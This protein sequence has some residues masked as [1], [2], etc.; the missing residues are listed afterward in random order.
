MACRTPLHIWPTRQQQLEGATLE[1][2]P[3]LAG[4]RAASAPRHGALR[5][6]PYKSGDM[7]IKCWEIGPGTA[8][9]DAV[10]HIAK[11]ASQPGQSPGRPQSPG[12]MVRGGAVGVSGDIDAHSE[13]SHEPEGEEAEGAPARSGSGTAGIGGAAAA[14]A[15]VPPPAE[16]AQGGGGGGSELGSGASTPR[17]SRLIARRN[18]LAQRPSLEAAA[19]LMAPRSPS[20]LLHDGGATLRSYGLR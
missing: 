18:S 2:R 1:R 8:V 4:G 10:A 14:G 15:A 6:T 19:A 17:S 3:S 16:A 20:Q 5:P 13:I 11:L 9:Q 7:P 12:R